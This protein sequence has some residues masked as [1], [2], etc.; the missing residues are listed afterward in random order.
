MGYEKA[1]NILKIVCIVLLLIL[2]FEIKYI[3]LD[4]CDKCELVLDDKIISLSY[5][6][7]EYNK[8]CVETY[9]E[10]EIPPKFILDLNST[11]NTP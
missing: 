3:K 11:Y 10:V 6:M 5:F 9:Q 1:I 7:H 4:S 2:L 8:K